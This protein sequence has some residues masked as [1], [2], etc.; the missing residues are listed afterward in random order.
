VCMNPANIVKGIV[1]PRLE[2]TEGT[3]SE[4]DS[5]LTV[6]QGPTRTIDHSKKKDSAR[7]TIVE[8]C[9]RKGFQDIGTSTVN[10][11]RLEFQQAA[12][13]WM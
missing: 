3:T 10:A 4:R 5:G 11:S 7:P 8:P 2:K 1:Q 12:V 13:A 6:G 9:E